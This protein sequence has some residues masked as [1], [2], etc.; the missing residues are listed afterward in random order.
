MTSRLK[1][2]ILVVLAYLMVLQMW[3]PYAAAGAATSRSLRSDPPD[4]MVQRYEEWIGQYGRVYSNETEKAQRFTVFRDNAMFIDSFNQARNQS[5]TLAI[6]EFA[7]L[8]NE[9]F[10]STRL[11]YIAP[12][13]SVVTTPFIYENITALP[14]TV[15]WLKSGAVTP[16]KNQE[17]CG[18]CWAFSAVAATEGLTKITTG[19]LISLSEQQLV[20]CD[21]ISHGCNGGWMQAGFKYIT[22]N[23]GIT[24]EQNY[25]YVKA[26]GPCQQNK[27][28]AMAAKLGGF[29]NVPQNSE[30][31][32]MKAVAHQ[33]VSVSIDAAGQEMQFYGGG[34]FNAACS[35]IINHGVTAIGYG[36]DPA[37]TK[38]WLIKNSWGANWGEQGYL[39][40]LKDNGVPEGICGIATQASFPLPAK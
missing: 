19:K 37:G 9:E 33:P 11:G 5:F 24:T 4:E 17:Q 31:D 6:N 35:T 8:T 32:L 34:I 20:D 12:P 26:Q 15:D 27:A 7:D 1:K 18:C 10:R 13:P 23:N 28:S 2:C 39:R 22:E 21:H 40:L 30:A 25:P 36:T 29:V 3:G 38:Y 14:P 16:I